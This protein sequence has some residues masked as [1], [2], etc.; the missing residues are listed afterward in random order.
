MHAAGGAGQVQLTPPLLVA[1]HGFPTGQV[2]T[3]ACA[4]P[5]LSGEQ[6]TTLPLE[7]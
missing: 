5:L 1:P 6:V 4:Q 3:T 7:Q 2:V